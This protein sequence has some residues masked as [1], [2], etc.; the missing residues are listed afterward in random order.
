MHHS[1]WAHVPTARAPQREK[2]LRW[3][4]WTLQQRVD[5]ACC[6][7]RRSLCSNEDPVQPEINTSFKKIVDL[8]RN[9]IFYL[10]RP[11]HYNPGD[12][13]S[14]SS[15]NCSTLLEVRAQEWSF[16]EKAI[17]KLLTG[18]TVQ[19]YTTKCV[20]GHGSSWPLARLKKECCHR[21]RSA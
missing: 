3:D 14:E 12:C 7:Q 20:V 15:E 13:L 5:P 19:I 10:H 9:E 2:S 11:E 8:E 4:A 17:L 16:W 1:Y 6:C 21:G 18:Y